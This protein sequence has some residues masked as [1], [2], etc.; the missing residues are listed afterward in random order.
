MRLLFRPAIPAQVFMTVML[1][2]AAHPAAADDDT[3]FPMLIGSS[4]TALLGTKAVDSQSFA[5]KVNTVA[6]LERLKG[7]LFFTPEYSIQAQAT[8]EPL[9]VALREPHKDHMASDEGLYLEQ[10]YAKAEIGIL[11]L[12]GG[13]F[14]VP[15]S[16]A[17]DTGPG[18]FGGDYA[19]DYQ[20][21]EMMG[22]GGVLRIETD[23]WGTYDLG[24]AGIFADTTWL[25]AA[26]F[27]QPNYGSIDTART[28][29]LHYGN[30]GE[31]NTGNL[32]SPVMTLNGDG[33]ALD[34]PTL[35]YHLVWAQLH[36]GVND[37]KDQTDLV[38]TLQYSGDLGDGIQ[39]RPLV[40]GARLFHDG[41]SP[42][43][44][45]SAV[46]AAQRGDYL[47]TG[48]EV[49]WEGWS[50]SGVR[51]QRMLIEPNNGTGL[52]GRSSFEH[53]LTGSIGYAFDFGLSASIAW[54]HDHSLAPDSLLNV[55]TDSLGV[56]FN[57]HQDF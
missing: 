41:G 53:F 52:N 24:A 6:V 33:T 8:Y 51:A 14:D 32:Q 28:G 47:T 10:L 45:N 9:R 44:S 23:G 35:T 1:S 27:T 31:A 37:A 56:L 15:I 5:R 4:D 46:P 39:V 40:E 29:R 19:T 36:H 21:R 11:M 48:I 13:K 7:G 18:I 26:A 50:I 12:Y 34:L 22:L 57:Y 43:S 55:N 54:K 20:L 30:G 16:I 42:V 2:M 49:S 25:D 3:D 38:A 17:A